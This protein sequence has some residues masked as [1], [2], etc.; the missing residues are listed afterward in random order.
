MTLNCHPD[1]MK[2]WSNEQF[3]LWQKAK[4]LHQEERYSEILVFV[5]SLDSEASRAQI[6]SFK[7]GLY[8]ELDDYDSASS[9]F[10]WALQLK[11]DFEPASLGLFHSR[12]LSGNFYGAVSEMDRFLRIRESE[13]YR[14]VAEEFPDQF[15]QAF[16]VLNPIEYPKVV[17]YLMR[18]CLSIG[19]AEVGVPSENGLQSTLRN[20]SSPNS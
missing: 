10:E 5:D 1:W 7:G 8:L 20:L 9:C 14:E 12:A 6:C 13:K 17:A 19:E 16:E 18:A 11:P 15:R 4:D 2:D 3:K